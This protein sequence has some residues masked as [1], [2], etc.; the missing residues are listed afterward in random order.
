MEPPRVEPPHFEQPRME[1]PRVEPPRF[2]QPRVEPPRVEPPHFEKPRMEPPRMGQ[3][4]FEPPRMEPIQPRMGQPEGGFRFEPPQRFELIRNEPYRE[5][6]RN[7]YNAPAYNIPER[8]VFNRG[9]DLEERNIGVEPNPRP[10]QGQNLRDQILE[11]IDQALGPGHRRAPRHL[12]RK[13]YL[14]RIDREEWP[15]GFKILDFTMFS[16][17]DE[18]TAL[19]HISRFTIQCGVYSNN[20]NGKLRLFPNSLTGQAFT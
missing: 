6:F 3:P 14:E 13:P 9:I 19:E 1:P 16:G 8:D 10:A 15:K 4:Q 12:Y 11:V 2:K 5:Q 7:A 20:G 17:D 18:K